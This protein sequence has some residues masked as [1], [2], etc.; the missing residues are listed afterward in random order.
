M[1][2]FWVYPNKPYKAGSFEIREWSGFSDQYNSWEPEKMVKD[3]LLWNF[4][5]N[6]MHET[7]NKDIDELNRK[8]S[9]KLWRRAGHMRG[10]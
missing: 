5:E 10:N 2:I 1:K 3:L 4:A 7:T 6:E 9:G 8:I